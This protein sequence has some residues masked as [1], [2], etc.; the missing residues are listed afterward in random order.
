LIS[1]IYH[2][3]F[4][5]L[6]YW[7]IMQSKFLHMSL[8][9][10]TVL[11]KCNISLESTLHHWQI[12]CQKIEYRCNIKSCRSNRMSKQWTC[13]MIVLVEKYCRMCVC[14]SLLSTCW[15]KIYMYVENHLQLFYSWSKSRS[16]FSTNFLEDVHAISRHSFFIQFMIDF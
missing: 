7:L 13:A 14:M 11:V 9:M 10:R 6:M 1:S 15:K 3:R 5:A 2:L 12:C 8:A 16:L 4:E